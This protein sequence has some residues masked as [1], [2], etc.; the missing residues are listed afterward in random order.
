MSQLDMFFDNYEEIFSGHYDVGHKEFI[1]ENPPASCRFCGK[2][3][4]EVSFDNEA[5]AIPEL[6]GN[7]QLV[8]TDECDTCNERF[9]KQIED[10]LGKFTQSFRV[11]SQ[12][13]G[14]DGIPSYKT[15]KK[16]SRVD[17]KPV[18]GLVIKQQ[19]GDQILE[20]VEGENRA[21]LHF[22]VEKHVP[23]AVYK[24][25]VK[26]ALSVIPRSE[27]DQ[28]NITRKWILHADH[29]KHIF[30][31]LKLLVYFIP[32]HRPHQKTSVLLLKKK[33]DSRV[34]ELP[35]YIQVLAF[36]NLQLQIMVP[37]LGD[38]REGSDT[39]TFLVPRFPSAFGDDWPFGKPEPGVIDLSSGEVVAASKRTLNVVYGGIEESDG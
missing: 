2:G 30:L 38:K 25:L 8:V 37:S 36:G 19:E 34:I 24:A 6:L 26:I 32:G 4:P 5:H 13:R 22:V 39:S 27:M 35:H 11:I 18:E 7:R 21:R 16:L 14:K 10:H 20:F 31:P 33:S 28:F 17:V 29:T 9:A 15:P 23:A 3:T 1:G 12:W